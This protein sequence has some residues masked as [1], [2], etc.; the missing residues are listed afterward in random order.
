MIPNL[1]QKIGRLREISFREV[2][3]WAGQ[4]IDL[5]RYDVFIPILF[6]RTTIRKKLQEPT[7]SVLGEKSFQ[8]MGSMGFTSTAYSILTPKWP[9]YRRKSSKWE[10]PLWF[11]NTRFVLFHC[12][13][14]EKALCICPLETLS[15]SI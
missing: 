6:C 12:F 2:G 10:G 4:E 5:D 13:C 3:E 1:L 14:C 11:K 7:E 9:H 15:K 8:Q